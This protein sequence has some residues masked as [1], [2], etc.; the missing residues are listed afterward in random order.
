MMMMM[1]MERRSVE[2]K[3]DGR[4]IDR[5]CGMECRAMTL[6]SQMM[7]YVD[8]APRFGKDRTMGSQNYCTKSAQS[9]FRKDILYFLFIWNVR[10]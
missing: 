3:S 1:M 6:V 10:E 4:T 7:A 5:C 9:A 2:G 8:A